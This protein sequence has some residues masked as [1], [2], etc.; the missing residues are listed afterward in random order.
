MFARMEF[1][2]EKEELAVVMEEEGVMLEGNRA[3]L[4]ACL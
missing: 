4:S 2:L 3:L 1:G